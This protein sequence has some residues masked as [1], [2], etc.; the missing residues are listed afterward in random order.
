[1]FRGQTRL[2]PV[3][4]FNQADALTF[5]VFTHAQVEEIG[6]RVQ[7]VGVEVIN[8]AT[9]HV[10]LDQYKSGASDHT[11]LSHT[12]A[13]GHGSDEVGLASPERTEQGHYGA[14]KQALC[15]SM[16]KSHCPGQICN[17]KP[18]RLWHLSSILI[19][20]TSDRGLQAQPT[21]RATL[22]HFRM[23]TAHRLG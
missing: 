5:Q 7:P 4:P 22:A 15:Q 19:A 18:D 12:K 11:A 13:L 16:A 10:F 14:G 23:W 3:C 6:G 2:H 20:V 1:M 21:L 9:T 17:F 8:G